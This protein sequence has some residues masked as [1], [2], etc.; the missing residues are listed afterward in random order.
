MN[1]L[2]D[3]KNLS[4][5]SPHKDNKDCIWGHEPANGD[6]PTPLIQDGILWHH[7][8][9]CKGLVDS[10]TNPS[11]TDSGE[12]IGSECRNRLPKRTTPLHLPARGWP[13]GYG[14]ELVEG[15]NW[16]LICYWELLI[17]LVSMLFPFLWA[18]LT[19]GEDRL[20]VAYTIGT[21]MFGAGQ[22]LYLIGLVISEVLGF[23]RY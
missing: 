2:F 6:I 5:M 18:T 11:S 20:V 1:T 21:W 10:N 12:E 23:W 14:L 13:I 9:H 16:M 3:P 17:G 19:A 22:V 15:F 7:W 8:C 4:A